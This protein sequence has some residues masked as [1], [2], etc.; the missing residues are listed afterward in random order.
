MSRTSD[1]RKV[2]TEQVIEKLLS[3]AADV[4]KG[5]R[6]SRVHVDDNAFRGQRPAN[7]PGDALFQPCTWCTDRYMVVEFIARGGFADIYGAY[8]SV[9]GRYVALKVLRADGNVQV[10]EKSAAEACKLKERQHPN[11]V[12]VYDAGLTVEGGVRLLFIAMELLDGASLLQHILASDGPGHDPR[13]PAILLPTL[14]AWGIGIVRGLGEL[15]RRKVV[16]RDLKPENIQITSE[17]PKLYDLNASKFDPEYDLKTT[18]KGFTLGTPSY[19]SPEHIQTGKADVRSDIYQVSFVLAEC[20]LGHHWFH[21]G[22]SQRFVFEEQH[23]WHRTRVPPSLRDFLPGIPPELD[24]L[25]HRCAEKDPAKRIQTCSELE[26]YLIA[27]QRR[28]AAMGA[29]GEPARPERVLVRPRGAVLAPNL[30]DAT[31]DQTPTAVPSSTPLQILPPPLFRAG[32]PAPAGLRAVEEAGEAARDDS[33]PQGTA[34]VADES[35]VVPLGSGPRSASVGAAPVPSAGSTAAPASPCPRVPDVP[36]PVSS[37][38]HG[39]QIIRTGEPVPPPLVARDVTQPVTDIGGAAPARDVTVPLAEPAREGVAGA[40]SPAGGAGRPATEARAP[41]AAALVPPPAAPR[42][43]AVRSL[44]ERALPGA[45]AGLVI[46]VAV[47]LVGRWMQPGASSQAAP[48]S[49]VA[50]GPTAAGVAPAPASPQPS[51]E[52]VAQPPAPAVETPPLGPAPAPTASATVTAPAPAPSPPAPGPAK[53]AAPPPRPRPAPAPPAPAE[54]ASRP[55]ATP[56][57]KGQK[58]PT[59]PSPRHE[60]P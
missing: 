13:E 35:G 52:P 33:A 2:R 30:G 54:P 26:A 60:D 34:A 3:E 15:H 49:T 55:T 50:P 27:F 8:D 11:V 17:G 18:G 4:P 28:L 48:T 41:I 14:T 51:S 12:T 37:G 10:L 23:A 59:N 57:K 44:I 45:V 7:W 16:H 46:S 38:P 9:E 19:M 36:A 42:Q 39:T 32:A 22:R 29:S 25:L 43:S 21:E 31:T 5:G 1:S 53:A 40:P 56:W 20:V 58:L 6:P 24:A 47:L